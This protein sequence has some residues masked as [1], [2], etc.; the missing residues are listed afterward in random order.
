MFGFGKKKKE[1]KK[2]KPTPK[3]S[4]AKKI[5]NVRQ[6]TVVTR[7]TSTPKKT[8][9]PNKIVPVTV[10]KHR[11]NAMLVQAYA[12]EFG[13][14]SFLVYGG[15]GRRGGKSFASVLH[16]FSLVEVELE[17]KPHRDLHISKEI[18]S[19]V[20]L[21]GILFDPQKSTLAIF[22]AEILLSSLKT[23]EKDRALFTFLKE[24]VLTLDRLD[25]GIANFHIA[26]LLKF[27][28]FLGVF[29]N[30]SDLGT[31]GYFDMRQAEFS[32]SRPLHSQHI[33][34]G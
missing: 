23:A 27:T 21:N 22:L 26:F 12:S 11:D 3:K 6:N 15:H 25:R 5:A 18:K 10:K 9:A 33:C 24:S 2:A 13:R 29:P 30:V 34:N 8:V 4:G 19:T 20:P 17:M 7:R 31:M 16:P 1:I 32:V 28:Y 14:I